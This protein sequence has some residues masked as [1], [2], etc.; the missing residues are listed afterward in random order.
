[1]E[2]GRTEA[3][4]YWRE[5]ASDFAFA[6]AQG[7][8]LEAPGLSKDSGLLGGIP[9][10][11]NRRQGVA[12]R[13]PAIV[14]QAETPCPMSGSLRRHLEHPEALIKAFQCAQA[15]LRAQ[16]QNAAKRM[17]VDRR[18]ELV[19]DPQASVAGNAQGDVTIV[20]FFDYRC[21]SC[22]KTHPG[23]AGLLADEPGAHFVHKQLPVLVGRG[24][25]D[26]VE[27]LPEPSIKGTMVFPSSSP[28][29]T[30]RPQIF[31]PAVGPTDPRRPLVEHE[32]R[33]AGH[34]CGERSAIRCKA[35]RRSR[36]HA[37]LPR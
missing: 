7:R 18:G 34:G 3:G 28:P 9:G 4:A 21:T 12:R 37:V 32:A 25:I 11:P 13:R 2:T 17:L 10:W 33:S 26:G 24:S 8:V 15:T 30:R 20:E 19:A 23:M 29:A 35:E 1:M 31:R 22:K 6:F 16:Q 5:A 27:A 36:K 14:K